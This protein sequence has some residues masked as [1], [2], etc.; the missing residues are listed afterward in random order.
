[1][2]ATA[3]LLALAAAPVASAQQVTVIGGAGKRGEAA[4]WQGTCK[5]RIFVRTGLLMVGIPAPTVTGAN[6][7]R[8]TRR[9]RTSVRYRV[10]VTDAFN[11]FASL[12]TSSWSGFI[13]VRQ[14]ERLT[15][16]GETTFEMDW[17]GN[18]GAN[19]L[20]EWWKSK[21]TIGWR[22]YRLSAFQYF[23]QYNVGPFGPLSS[24]YKYHDYY[25]ADP[26]GN[27]ITR[28]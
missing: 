9:E 19:I 23:D 16:T 8:R 12:S 14:S 11:N 5:Y 24:C 15:W 28:P 22:V 2:A 17:R 4:L 3:V 1:M 7:R 13:R 21:R 25:G 20:I 27:G 6:T 10:E 18:Y 26:N